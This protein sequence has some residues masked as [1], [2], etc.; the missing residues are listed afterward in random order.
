MGENVTNVE[1]LDFTV[2]D[3]ASPAA[4]KMAK[5]F[6]RVHHAAEATTHKLGELTH[7]AA[8]S[9]LA[10]VGLGIGFHE[11][12]SKAGEANLELEDAAKKIAGVQYTFGGWKAGTTGQEKW[13]ASLAAGT[14]V[15]DRLEASE[16]KLRLGR[17]EL[18][19]IYKSAF[20][21][22]ARHN[23]S[24]EQMLDT[25]EKLGAVQKVLGVN[26][27]FAAMQITRM[28]LSGKIR[29]FD[30]FSK[31]LRFAL[32]DMKA[33]AKLSEEKRFEKIQKA[34]GDLM[35]AAEGMGKGIRGS[36]F[37]AKKAV[38]ELTR[39]VSGPLFKE[40]TK[41]TAE[42]AHQ[43]LEVRENGQSAAKIYGDK[44]VTAFG[45]LKSA[46]AFIADHWKI[47]AGIW[48]ATKFTGAMQGLAGRFG[49]GAAGVAGAGGVASGVMNVTAATVNVNGGAAAA[50]G[51][52]TATELSTKLR[53][54]MSDTIGRYA[55][56]GAKIGMVTEALGG[57]YIGLD[58]LAS[59]ALHEQAKGIATAAAAPRAMTSLTAGA[60][61]MSSALHEE[62]VEKTFGHLQSAFAAYGLKPGQMLSRET[63]ASELKAMEPSLA[64]KQLGMYGIKGMSA[65]GVQAPGV[66]DE[67]AGRVANLLNN[68]ASQL[69]AANP[70]LG[71]GGNKL[72][73]KGDTHI[74]VASMTITPD[75]KDPHPDMV[76]HQIATGIIQGVRSPTGSNLSAVPSG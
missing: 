21:L 31:T 42:W 46:T 19:D 4:E 5:S 8:M 32:G 2:K 18:S 49:A 48:A 11:I 33:F 43:L 40:V 27:E 71:K 56:M 68:F 64:A 25:T 53:P 26:A 39:D 10:M 14:E 3:H 57:L 47:I 63:L 13:A 24:Q 61:A 76:W 75:F 36:V 23:L 38:D 15:V 34:M 20:A 16:S 29:G 62:S 70:E 30:D 45:Y 69:L 65:K 50:L 66:L 55:A 12:A 60:K 54:T 28:A 73:R 35:P 67:A 1:G 6:E 17:G 7:H 59:W 9:G 22:G 58:A 74:H 52:A 72:A 37:D 51:A 41:D 44:L